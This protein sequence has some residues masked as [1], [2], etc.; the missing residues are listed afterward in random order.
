MVSSTFATLF[1]WSQIRELEEEK[2]RLNSRLQVIKQSIFIISHL[3]PWK[4]AS[5]DSVLFTNVWH[6]RFVKWTTY[7]FSYIVFPYLRTH[8]LIYLLN[9]SSSLFYTHINDYL[10]IDTSRS[11]NKRNNYLSGK[12]CYGVDV[13]ILLGRIVL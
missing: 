9:G 4:F 2:Q 11:Y 10:N 1:H 7:I 3:N 5:L 13:R 6:C 12:I 8:F